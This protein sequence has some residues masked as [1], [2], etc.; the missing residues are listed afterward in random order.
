MAKTTVVFARV[1]TEV[2]EKMKTF[3]HS[4]AFLQQAPFG[5]FTARLFV[6]TVFL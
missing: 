4:S 6:K 3:S 5:C 2:K 1:D